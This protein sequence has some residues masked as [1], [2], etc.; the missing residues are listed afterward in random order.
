MKPHVISLL[1]ILTAVATAA[2]VPFE[3]PAD[4]SAYNVT[5]FNGTLSQAAGIGVGSPS[6]GGLRYQG[7]NTSVERGA[8]VRRTDSVTPDHGI[9]TTSILLNPK[10][11]D[12]GSSD[13]TEIRLGFASTDNT[14]TSKPWEYF[15]K[16][17]NSVS[18]KLK[19]EGANS[20]GGFECEL[21]HFVTGE[22]KLET[23]T[24]NASPYFNDWLRLSL[25]LV[26]A[27][28]AGFTAHYQLESL[29]A[30]GTSAPAVILTSTTHALANS[31]LAGASTIHTGFSIKGEKSRTNAVY[32][33][34]HV[35][36]FEAVA[37]DA[38]SNAA[39]ASVAAQS[40]TAEWQAPSG[41]IPSS[42]VLEVTTAADNFAPGTF[43]SATGA[44]GQA[45]GISVATS[46][47][48]RRC[49]SCRAQPH[50]DAAQRRQ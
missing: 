10:E 37:P 17:N 33:D 36:S 45:T 40:V 6:T 22:S 23:L 47:V 48:L 27:G 29:G 11:F 20:V 3:S 44:T 21:T 31:T 4:L 25:K 19:A 41:I 1:G 13:K 7:P 30:D 15:N 12:N 8:I 43:I 34:D 18:V 28:S 39:P 42:Y 9:W 38:P 14:S 50:R 5:N 26:R 49:G 35:A 32:L 24:A 46:A 2:T 16:L